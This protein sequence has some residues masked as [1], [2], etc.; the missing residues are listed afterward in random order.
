MANHVQSS[1]HV[2]DAPVIA[3]GHN[4]ETVTEAVAQIPLSKRTP[5][6]WVFGFLIGL[7][8]LG[9]LTMALG[10]LLLNGIG[11]WGNNIPVAWAFDIINF[12]WWIGIGHAGTLFSAI[13]LLFNQQWRMSISRFA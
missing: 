12:V 9:G 5:L 2:L 3:P 10:W 1:T 6:G 4:L 8:L 7:A 11:I 13:L